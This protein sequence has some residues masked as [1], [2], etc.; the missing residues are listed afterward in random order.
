MLLEVDGTGWGGL[1]LGGWIGLRRGAL[2]GAEREADLIVEI[3]PLD[4]T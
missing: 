1:K 4:I 2:V 3:F